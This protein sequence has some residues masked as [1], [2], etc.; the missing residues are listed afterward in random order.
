MYFV[1]HC[2]LKMAYEVDR[3]YEESADDKLTRWWEEDES[4]DDYFVASSLLADMII[5]IRT[6][7]GAV[8]QS[9]DVH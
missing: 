6:K 5:Q 9:R 1:Y 4:D 8:D 3:L 7:G 2:I